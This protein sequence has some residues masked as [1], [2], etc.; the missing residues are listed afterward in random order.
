MFGIG[1]FFKKIQSSY[2][3]EIFARSVIKG[4]VK[5]FTGADIPLESVSIR[6]G[7]ATLRGISQ[8]L[9]SAIYIKKQAI[10]DDMTATQGMKNVT[11][12]R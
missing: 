12:I 1:E 4:S 10:I 7:V 5:K 3:K 2:T 9:R 6:D 8:S 11:D